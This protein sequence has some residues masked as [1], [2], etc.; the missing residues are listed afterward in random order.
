MK[1]LILK[2]IVANVNLG[3]VYPP[4]QVIGI[5]LHVNGGLI[6]GDI[7]SRKE[8][9][10]HSQNALIKPF[11]DAIIKSMEDENESFDD[12]DLETLTQIHLKNA[13]YINGSQR[14][15]LRGGTTITVLIDDVSAFNIGS[16]NFDK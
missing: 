5:T 10:E 16:L 3:D 9:Y 4:E 1:H 11:Y 13:A 7:I 8:Y 2:A 12:E 15:P 14:I 6:S